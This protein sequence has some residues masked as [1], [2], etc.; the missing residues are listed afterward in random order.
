MGGDKEGIA[1]RSCDED[2]QRGSETYYV[3]CIE[4]EDRGGCTG[5]VGKDT[6]GEEGGIVRIKT[7]REPAAIMWQAFVLEQFLLVYAT[8]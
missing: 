2:Y 8:I 6:S 3:R 5:A 1:T 7:L 4:E